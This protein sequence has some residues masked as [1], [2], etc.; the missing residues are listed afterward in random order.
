MKKKFKNIHLLIH[1][2]WWCESALT[3]DQKIQ[4][5]FERKKDVFMTDYKN[6]LVQYGAV[7]L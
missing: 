4:T 2:I 5:N 3:R 6:I 1:P 7:S